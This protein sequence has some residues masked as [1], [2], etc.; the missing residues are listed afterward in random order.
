QVRVTSMDLDTQLLHNAARRQRVTVNTLIQAVWVLLLQRYTGQKRVAF[1]ATV[2]GRSAQVP[3]IERMLGLFINTLPLVQ[4]PESQ[5]KVGDWLNEL[6]A[7][8]LKL[9]EH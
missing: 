7:H 2:S 3:G 9:R 6:Q 4:A 5:Q 1:G 8:N